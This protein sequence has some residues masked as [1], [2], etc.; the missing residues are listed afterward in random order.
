MARKY[1]TL[2]ERTP[3]QLWSPEFGDYDRKVVAQEGDDRRESGDFIKGTKFKIITT[4]GKQ[5]S[6]TDAVNELNARCTAQ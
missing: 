4:D 3:G 2:L 1:Y 6:I 5:A